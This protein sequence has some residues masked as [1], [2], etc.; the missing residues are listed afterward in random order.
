MSQRLL[1]RADGRGRVPA[2]EILTGTAKAIDCIADPIRIHELEQVLADG[3]V[4]RH[5]DPPAGARRPREGRG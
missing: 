3:H 4:P 1:E 2:V 5:A